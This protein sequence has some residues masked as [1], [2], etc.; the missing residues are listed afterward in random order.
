MFVELVGVIDEDV[1]VIIGNE[2]VVFYFDSLVDIMG[3]FS[4][5]GFNGDLSF[6]K[7]NIV[8]FGV[9]IFFGE[10]LDVLDYIGENFLFKNGIFM[11]FFYVVG[12][13]VLLK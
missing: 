1:I 2:V 5:C 4:F 8:V 13:V 6:L 9:C 11:V 7:L 12:V 3:D 10:L